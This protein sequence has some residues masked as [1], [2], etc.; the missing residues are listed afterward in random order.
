MVPRIMIDE[1]APNSAAHDAGLGPGDI[2]IA[3][4]EPVSGD[5][6]EGFTFADANAFTD[7]SPARSSRSP[8]AEAQ[9]K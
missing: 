8:S 5:G 6:E 1:I 9:A 3:L 7:Q 4:G 2:I